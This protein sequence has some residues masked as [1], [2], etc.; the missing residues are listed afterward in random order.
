MLEG[1]KHE[2]LIRRAT[3]PRMLAAGNVS[4]ELLNWVTMAGTV[5]EIKPKFLET[6]RGR[7]YAVWKL[8]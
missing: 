6:E 7:G 1:G 2:S 5:G 4:G 8:D 3:E